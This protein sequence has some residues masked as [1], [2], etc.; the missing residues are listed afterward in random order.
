MPSVPVEIVCPRCKSTLTSADSDIRCEGCGAEYRSAED[1]PIL[2]PEA[3]SDQHEHQRRY[4]D[5]E[6]AE[7]ERYDPESWRASFNQRIFGA[8]GVLDGSTPY[9]D[10][11]V[12][13][14]GATVIEA[15]RLGV[16]SVGC[17]LSVP[18]VLAARRFAR[19]EGVDDNAR[20]VVCAAEALPFAD[21]S[22]GS[23]SAVALLEH[24][25]DDRPTVAELARVVR[26]GGL[27]WVT[28]PHAFR[29]MLP[30]VWPFYWWH[31]RRIGHK[32]HYDEAGLVRLCSEAGLE[33]LTTSF[34]GHPVKL[35][36]YAGTKLFPRMHDP[37]SRAWWRLERLDLRAHRRRL[38][39]MQL[40]A[41]FRRAD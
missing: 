10:T 40:S 32:R 13:G 8:L 41:V 29:Y 11:G 12:G 20:F 27:L 15:A 21:A 4:F 30:L 36:Q 16:E 28:V 31:D 37:S 35:V 38:G 17:D 14:S 33:H 7:Y 22:F 6:F 26:P 3:L 34:S 1:V 5:A 24:L 2:L 23:A 19:A 9:L 25:D 18:G 39:A